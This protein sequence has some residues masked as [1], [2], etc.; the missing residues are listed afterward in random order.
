[1]M[2]AEEKKKKKTKVEVEEEE[3]YL[4]P[5]AV[6]ANRQPRPDLSLSLSFS[7]SFSLF[8]SLFLSLSLSLCRIGSLGW[9]PQVL[10]WH[11]RN[12]TAEKKT[13]EKSPFPKM[14]PTIRETVPT[15]EMNE[16]EQLEAKVIFLGRYLR[17]T[18]NG[19][20]RSI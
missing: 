3:P 19:E 2:Q 11:H 6:A 9:A 15:D 17:L 8:L 12:R 16:M 5:S 18:I 14:S 1:M 10:K 4:H 7:L 20:G 13:M